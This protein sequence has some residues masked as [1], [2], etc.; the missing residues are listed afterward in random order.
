MQPFLFEACRNDSYQ[1]QI[2][3][4]E[5]NK[6]NLEFNCEIFMYVETS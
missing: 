6:F 2:K 3:I 1:L 5:D 4:N